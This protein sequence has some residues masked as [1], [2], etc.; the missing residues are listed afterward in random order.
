MRP[1]R[2]FGQIRP[3]TT[4]QLQQYGARHNFKIDDGLAAELVPVLA[5]MIGIFDQ[6][7]KLPQPPQ[8]A[9]AF[10]SREIGREPTREE[11]PFNAFI[12]FCRVEG[13][14]DG[15]LKG[16]TAAIKD[17]VAVAGMPTTNGSRMLPTL[18]ATEDVVVE[19]ILGAGA[20]IVGKTNMEDM[21]HGDR[22]GKRLRA[23]AESE[24]AQPR[25]RRLVEWLWSGR[26]VRHG[27][28]RPRSR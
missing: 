21:A 2:E 13:A 9:S 17:C 8:P 28:F 24:Q 22:R 25:D 15:L 16:L 4:A 6:I 10:T 27:R 12:R 26:R 19:R 14:A 1:N 5:E 11:D 18:I 3:P 7:D 20:T 23:R